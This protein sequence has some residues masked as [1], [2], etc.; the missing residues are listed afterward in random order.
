MNSDNVL[1]KEF[2]I[3]HSSDAAHLIEQLKVEQLVP[4]FNSLPTELSVVLI[5]QMEIFPAVR[6]LEEIEIEQSVKLIENL[7][8]NLA[9]T[10]LR[11]MQKEKRDLILVKTP[12]QISKPLTEILYHA[13]NTAGGL[14]NPQV[15][16]ISEGLNIK[17][18]FEKVKKSKQ[19][20]YQY[21][22]VVGDD[23]KLL[24]IVKLEDLIIA[25]SKEQIDSVMDK[26]FPHLFSEVEIQKIFDHPGWLEY[27]ALPVLDREG[28]LLGE[29]K[30]NIIRK[31]KIDKTKTIPRHAILA[32]N[33]LGELYRIGLSGLF[34]STSSPK[35]E[36]E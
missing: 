31:T 17:E 16:I 27:N 22:Y 23:I 28:V 19:Q 36:I 34:Y 20:S 3:N 14:M 21:I 4:F 12:N 33:A 2:I 10:Y 30:Q 11:R 15:P 24:G 25:E 6:C 7:P 1:I 18:A 13:Q 29:L 5:S 26:E 32:S 35:E 8:I 9:S